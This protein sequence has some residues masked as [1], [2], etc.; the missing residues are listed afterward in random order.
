AKIN[1]ATWEI[2][3]L[4]GKFGGVLTKI[5]PFIPRLNKIIRPKNHAF[6]VP[7][8]D[9]VKNNDSDLLE[10]LFDGILFEEKRNLLLWWVDEKDGLY[11][12]IQAKTD[13]GILHKLIGVSVAHVVQRGNSDF[14]QSDSN[15]PIYTSG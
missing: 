7:E 10:E 9:W 5:I 6:V 3:R 13:W 2:K 15:Q 14:N 1:V 12:T 4:P 11:K 8:A